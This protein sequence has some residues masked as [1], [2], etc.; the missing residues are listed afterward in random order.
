MKSSDFAFS[1]LMP[2]PNRSFEN[3]SVNTL[4]SYSYLTVLPM[5]QVA[6]IESAKLIPHP[7]QC[8]LR[9]E[10]LFLSILH[11]ANKNFKHDSSRRRTLFD[12]KRELFQIQDRIFIVNAKEGIIGNIKKVIKRHY[13]KTGNFT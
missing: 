9:P 3:F 12:L 7:T 8:A 6:F 2:L 4:T 13:Q 1:P 10:M 5:W 11:E